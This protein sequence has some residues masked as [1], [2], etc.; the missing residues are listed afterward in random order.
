M[1]SSGIKLTGTFTDSIFQD[2]VFRDKQAFYT[3]VNAIVC[4]IVKDNDNL[5]KSMSRLWELL[6]PES[7]YGKADMA[8]KS[9]ERIS[10]MPDFL[11]VTPKEDIRTVLGINKK[12]D[13]VPIK[14]GI[15]FKKEDTGKKD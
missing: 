15:S 3:A 13:A 5:Q 4:A 6:F 10:R 14:P 2:K 11:Y 7:E 8:A 1:V 12:E 9:A